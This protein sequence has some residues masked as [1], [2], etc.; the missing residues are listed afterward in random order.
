[1]IF[2]KLI[3][4]PDEVEKKVFSS[5]KNGNA[6]LFTYFNQH[7]FNVYYSDPEYRNL[8]DN[9]FEVFLD[10]VGI[11]LALKFFLK[12]NVQ[13][14]NAT[15]LNEKIFQHFSKQQTS[16]YLI[17]GKFEER[18]INKKAEDKKINVIGYR[19]GY[20]NEKDIPLIVEELNRVLP[21]VIVIAMGAPKQEILA[22]KLSTLV[23]AKL[24]LCVG[25]FLEFYLESKKRVP[26]VFRNS[27]LEWLYR[28]IQEPQRLWKRYLAGIPLFFFNLFKMKFNSTRLIK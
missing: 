9:R 18:F 3:T 14:F 28:L 12:K 25:G 15:D 5:M 13:R 4:D 26:K 20:F 19:N 1:M 2:N 22:N 27:G 23:Q 16:L 21:E 24:I 8:M 6:T 10:G 17:G 7:C 11:Y